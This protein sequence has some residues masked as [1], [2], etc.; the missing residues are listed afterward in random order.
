MPCHPN[1]KLI[2]TIKRILDI[3]NVYD[4]YQ[5]I[6]PGRPEPGEWVE[7]CLTSGS[8]HCFTWIWAP[9]L[10]L[11]PRPDHHHLA[12]TSCCQ[13]A[14]NQVSEWRV[15]SHAAASIASPGS[16]RPDC[17]FLKRSNIFWQWS[18]YV[19]SIFNYT[20]KMHA[21]IFVTSLPSLILVTIYC[22]LLGYWSSLK[23]SVLS[24]DRL[25]SFDAC[26]NCDI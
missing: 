26:K 6:L 14:Q 8:I 9:W 13:G 3:A 10:L 5:I 20:N 11:G 15:A 23:Y 21:T 4:I 7:G 22:T 19:W 17:K 16:G 1:E 24:S 12:D 2:T 18:L 25:N